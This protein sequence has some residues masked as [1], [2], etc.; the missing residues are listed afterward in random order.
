VSLQTPVDE[1]SYE[2]SGLL[3]FFIVNLNVAVLFILVFLVGRNVVKLI[4]DRRRGLLGSRLRT[5]LLIAFVGITLVPT[6]IL[7]VQASGLLSRAM[8]GWFSSQIEVA[9]D[10]AVE[11]G[12]RYY[13]RL[14]ADVEQISADIH[15]QYQQVQLALDDPSSVNLFLD[16][17]R[18]RHQLFGLALY[19][20]LDE[21]IGESQAPLHGISSFLVPPLKR[22]AFEQALQ[23][24]KSLQFERLEEAQFVRA[25]YPIV[26]DSEPVV[27]VVTYRINPEL[28]ELFSQV[29]TSFEEYEQ[30]K[31]LKH[32]LQSAFLL[33]LAMITG[34]ILFAAI[35][36]AFYLSRELSTPIQQLAEGI[37]RVARGKYDFQLRAGG[38]DELGTLV[39]GFN[40]MTKD[41]QRS[42]EQLELR[43]SF[44][45]KVL[46]NL[47]SAVIVLRQDTTIS[48]VNDRASE[49]GIVGKAERYIGRPIS[50]SFPDTLVA[51]IRRIV[52]QI[53]THASGVHEQEVLI[54]GRPRRLQIHYALLSSVERN[55]MPL[56]LLVIDDITELS[57]AQRMSVWREAAKRIA[58]EIKNPL[59]P[60]Q[61]SAQRIEKLI[62]RMPGLDKARGALMTILDNVKSIQR[63]AN[64]FSNFARMPAISPHLFHLAPMIEAVVKMFAENHPS[65]QFLVMNELESTLIQGD[66][67]QLRRMMV[68]VLA[69]AVS[70][71]GVQTDQHKIQVRLSR[72]DYGQS[73]KIEVADSGPGIPDELKRRIFDPYFTTK[74]EGTGLG[75]AIVGSIVSDHNGRIEVGD[76]IPHGAIF[77]IWL[78]IQQSRSNQDAG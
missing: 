30:L 44:I 55:M 64:E 9:V 15:E 26:F 6:A 46:S 47:T 50:G 56:I 10:G 77:R 58:H 24:S 31:V 68:N 33:T 3:I 19:K 5:R 1:L 62:D 2:G 67:E 12:R 49:L 28:V 65:I 8:E 11:I 20:A 75:L 60:I 59:T 63:L 52:S 42:R 38:D 41:L 40:Q 69:N 39:A 35:W 18:S 37:E 73:L 71:I 66:D 54:K 25:Y 13:Q 14:Y 61:L 4:F 74:G 70:A 72:D 17:Q 34:L 7:F 23:G 51:A 27:L 36:F 22:S 53:E 16:A 48:L 29:T 78:P 57:E 43:Q 45:E 32:Q 21:V 76:N